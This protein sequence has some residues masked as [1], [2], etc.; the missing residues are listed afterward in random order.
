MV[1]RGRAIFGR[2]CMLR[3]LET[4]AGL[5]AEGKRSLAR[6]GPE[7]DVP[8]RQTNSGPARITENLLSQEGDVLDDRLPRQG[9]PSDRW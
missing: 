2:D 5:M 9:D 4:M 8:G 1:N 7:L 6:D 3:L